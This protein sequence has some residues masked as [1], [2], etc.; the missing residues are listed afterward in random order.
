[1]VYG[2]PAN[3]GIGIV[4]PILSSPFATSLPLELPKQPKESH[5]TTVTPMRGE[6]QK[7]VMNAGEGEDFEAWRLLVRRRKPTSVLTEVLSRGFEGT[8]CH[9]VVA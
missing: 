1:M 2:L 4:L 5:H 7:L 8:P 9:A 3:M 6:A